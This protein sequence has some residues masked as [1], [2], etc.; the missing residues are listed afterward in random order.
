MAD[1]ELPFRYI[2]PPDPNLGR[3]V[4]TYF[5]LRVLL[6][7]GGMGAAYLAEH[8]GLSHVKCVIKLVL[9]E[10]LHH[11][12]VI[13]RYHN[14]AKALAVLR[15]D[16]IVKL[17]EFGVLDYGQL[18]LRLEYVEGSRSIATSPTTGAVAAS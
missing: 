6:G 14:E 8:E 3:R 9:V 10:M 7:R 13:S 5:I 15:H 17:Q 12:M 18:C 1:D 4:D 2:P 16:N 11:P